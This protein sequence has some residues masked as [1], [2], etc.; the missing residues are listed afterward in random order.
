MA[1]DQLGEEREDLVPREPTTTDL[2]ALCRELNA[3]GA[4]YL[5]CGGFAIRAAGYGRRTGDID[6]LIDTALENETIVYRA[7]ETLPDGAVRELD[8]GDVAKYIVVRVADEIVVDLMRSASGI[9][10]AE[11][12]QDVVITE[13]QGVPIPF[14]SPQ[15]LWRMKRHTRREKDAGDLVFLR[16]LFEA[17]GVTP[18]E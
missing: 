7:L 18:P 6:L 13:V 3:R 8:P 16:E 5:V 12:A 2:V 17:H 1:D 4:R 9:D 14:A 11:A 10:Y 15:L